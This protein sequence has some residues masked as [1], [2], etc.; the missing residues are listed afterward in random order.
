MTMKELMNSSQPRKE[1][2]RHDGSNEEDRPRDGFGQVFHGAHRGDR[3]EHAGGEADF[4]ARPHG[5]AEDESLDDEGRTAE[6]GGSGVKDEEIK[7]HMKNL[8][9]NNRSDFGGD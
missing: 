7:A 5:R 8:I 4:H 3:E 9:E 1:V 2:N 6:R